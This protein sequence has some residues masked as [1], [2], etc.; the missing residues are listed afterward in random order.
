M[1]AAT[2]PAYR[3][4]NESAALSIKD[5]PET[6]AWFGRYWYSMM[7]R[8]T[9]TAIVQ[10]GLGE[11]T[12]RM[13][14]LVLPDIYGEGRMGNAGVE[15]E[16]DWRSRSANFAGGSPKFACKWGDYVTTKI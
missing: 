13:S 6:L 3:D 12:R 5:S 11:L 10:I 1:K 2:A 8:C 16:D 14:V 15:W 7:R 9:L 4:E